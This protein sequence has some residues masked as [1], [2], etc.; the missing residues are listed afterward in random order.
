M[1]GPEIGCAVFGGDVGSLIL[2]NPAATDVKPMFKIAQN[3]VLRA[4][5][6]VP[7]SAALQIKKGMEAK[8]TVRERPGQIYVGKVM[9]TTNYLDPMNRSLLTEVKVPNPKEAEIVSGLTGDEQIIAN[10]GERVVE[11]AMVHAVNVAAIQSTV[12]AQKPQEK[13]SQLTKN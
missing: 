7:Q 4:F 13:V 11:G 5:V 12:E 2:A 10:P 9:G 8:I 6:N 3:D 1:V